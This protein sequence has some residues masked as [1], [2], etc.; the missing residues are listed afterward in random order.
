MY[1]EARFLNELTRYVKLVDEKQLN[2]AS[3]TC[4]TPVIVSHELPVTGATPF[5]GGSEVIFCFLKHPFLLVL[6]FF[7][8]VIL[9]QIHSLHISCPLFWSLLIWTKVFIL[10]PFQPTYLLGNTTPSYPQLAKYN[11]LI[12]S[13]K[14]S[15]LCLL[16]FNGVLVLFPLAFP[17]HLTLWHILLIT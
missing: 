17:T 13:G 16:L 6:S 9:D 12:F 3:Y 8:L 5:P 4:K 14:T 2:Y 7:F 15:L 10:Y 1:P 11:I